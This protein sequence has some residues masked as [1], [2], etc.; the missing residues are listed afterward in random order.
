LTGWSANCAPASSLGQEGD[1]WTTILVVEDEN[2]IRM[3]I[4]DHI[5]EGGFA[6]LA[7]PD[8]DQALD[9]LFKHPDINITSTDVDIPC[10]MD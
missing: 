3:S 4:A 8:A 5:E 7:A 1:P 10:S 9:L 2:L 6:V